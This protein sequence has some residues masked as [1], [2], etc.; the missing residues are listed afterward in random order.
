V[1]YRNNFINNTQSVD[2]DFGYP[3]TESSFIGVNSW[4]NGAQGNYWSDYLAKYPAAKEVN[5]TGVYDTPYAVSP[6]TYPSS[7]DHHPIVNPVEINQNIPNIPEFPLWIVPILMAIATMLA[8]EYSHSIFIRRQNSLC[9]AH[10]TVTISS[11]FIKRKEFLRR[12]NFK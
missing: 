12:N 6:P 3:Y 5:A 10:K 4:D 1:F 8:L 2:I 9:C 11:S 7:Y